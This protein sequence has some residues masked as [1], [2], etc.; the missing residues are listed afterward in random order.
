MPLN[1]L[2]DSPEV[3]LY[4]GPGEASSAFITG[5][6]VVASKSANQLKALVVSLRPQRARR[7]QSLHTVTPHIDLRTDLVADGSALPGVIHRSSSGNEHEW[8]FSISVPGTTAESVYSDAGFVAYELVAQAKM[9]GTLAS[10]VQSKALPVAIKRAPSVD[11]NWALH[12]SQPIC[13]S[14]VWRDQL[15]LTLI[16][17]SRIV[18]DQQA[19][20]VRG[21]IRPLHKGM[22]L[23]RTGFQLTERIRHSMDAHDRMYSLAKHKVVVDNTVDIPAESGTSGSSDSSKPTEQTGLPLMQ[24]TSASRC[25]SVPQAYTGIQYDI[26]RGPIRTSHELVFF[27]SIIDAD[28]RTHNLRLATPAFVLPMSAAKLIDLPRYEDR[29]ADELIESGI[30]A[31]VQRDESFM[32]EYVVVDTAPT[33]DFDTAEWDS[34]SVSALLDDEGTVS[35]C[36]LALDGYHCLDDAPPPPVYPGAS[37]I[38]VERTL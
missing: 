9:S 7:F 21:V 12:A 16:A 5:R 19:L 1:L 26:R 15:E 4:G 11:S 36:P 27:V 17:Q 35:N 28:K 37:V 32:A 24:E 10:V 38:S 34:L 31:G 13:E 18:H 22:S 29:G 33:D 25:L 6:V 8:R 3:I 14:V 2:L 30:D 23:V 20:S